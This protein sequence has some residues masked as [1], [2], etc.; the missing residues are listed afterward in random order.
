MRV[1]IVI[2]VHAAKQIPMQKQICMKCSHT[3]QVM[4]VINFLILNLHGL[5]ER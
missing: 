3:S 5:V 4:E 2:H 1:F